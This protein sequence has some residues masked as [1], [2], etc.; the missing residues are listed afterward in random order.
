M[1]D[2]TKIPNSNNKTISIII[3]VAGI[4]YGVSPIDAVP[5][6]IPFAGWIDDIVITGGA[7][8][9]L[10]EKYAKDMNT[11]LAMIIKLMKWAVLILGGILILLILLLG[12]TIMSFFK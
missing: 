9:N 2:F 11:S 5:D 4:V 8:L 6:V 10:A 7:L 12:A 1:A 3:A